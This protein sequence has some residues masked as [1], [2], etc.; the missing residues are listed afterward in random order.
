MFYKAYSILEE[1]K[2][3]RMTRPILHSKVFTVYAND[4]LRKVVQS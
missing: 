3:T 4:T 1:F 2:F